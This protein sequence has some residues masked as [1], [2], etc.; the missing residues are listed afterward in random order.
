MASFLGID[1]GTSSVKT[2]LVDY[3]GTV[4]AR[5]ERKNLTVQPHAGW[6]EQDPEKNWWQGAKETVRRCLESS[7][8]AD[9]EGISICGMVPNLTPLDQDGRVV[10]P[11]ILYRDG[12][13]VDEVADL[14]GRF[15]RPFFTQDVS[16]KL[17]W[18]KKHEP[19][20]AARI[21]MVLNAHSYLVYRLTGKYSIDRDS[22]SIFGGVYE[23]GK[24][25]NESAVCE[26]GL[27]PEVL[28]P[29]YAPL[30]IVG[31]T[32]EKSARELGLS[33]GIPVI[34]GTG[35]SFTVLVGSGTVG[36]GDAAIYLGTAATM[37]L[38][39][40][41]LDD[42]TDAVP[43]FDGDAHFLANVLMG[44]AL[45]EWCA[46]QA[47]AKKL[48]YLTLEDAASSVSPGSEGLFFLPDLL[49]R[50]SPAP[51]G[52]ARGKIFGLTPSH[53]W[54]HLYR[55]A[56]EGVA[57]SLYESYLAAGREIKRLR[58]VGGGCRSAVWRQ[59]LV[60]VFGMN[61]SYSPDADGTLGTAFLAALAVGAFSSYDE[62][63]S[64]WIK[65][66]ED[67]LPDPFAVEAYEKAFTRFR[68]LSALS[69]TISDILSEDL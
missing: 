51:D 30:D 68:K 42:L 44:G 41:S 57:F 53:S 1:I 62:I 58:L 28:P 60:S 54:Q 55:A 49:G 6:A 37:L 46:N 39:D 21:R 20:N 50:R 17:L 9:V 25:W 67:V 19:E 63:N 33:S 29:I 16:P 23:G 52:R 27:D 10:R 56:L 31:R 47:F 26:I 2:V 18:L 66:V 65:T 12:R 48:D 14:T 4:L 45:V 24:V 36:Q 15:R 35:D 61:A 34:A 22:A 8:R 38:L 69:G 43:F 3:G 5:A 11:A 32:T 40:R 64:C 59:I 13:A 7:G